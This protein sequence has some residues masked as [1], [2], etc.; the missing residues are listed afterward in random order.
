MS[1][2]GK[3]P[4]GSGQGTGFLP[5]QGLTVP[6]V[7]TTTKPIIAAA[8]AAKVETTTFFVAQGGWAMEVTVPKLTD[9]VAIKA[10][11]M[12]Q[13]ERAWRQADKLNAA[14]TARRAKAFTHG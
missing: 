5:P 9:P 8:Q 10:R 2:E 4:V 1:M 11:Q 12:E 3:S 7:E 6:P 14:Y 13:Q